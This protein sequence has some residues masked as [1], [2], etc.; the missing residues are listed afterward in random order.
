MEHSSE[1]QHT[2]NLA[3][4]SVQALLYKVDDETTLRS[5][6][7]ERGLTDPFVE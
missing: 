7:F 2:V 1:R 4:F 3:R 6:S 5:A